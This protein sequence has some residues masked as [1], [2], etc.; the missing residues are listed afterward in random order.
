[1]E[2]SVISSSMLPLSFSSSYQ[3]ISLAFIYASVRVAW[4]EM[5]VKQ[6]VTAIYGLNTFLLP[7][8]KLKTTAIHKIHVVLTPSNI[9]NKTKRNETK[10]KRMLFDLTTLTRKLTVSTW[11]NTFIIWWSVFF[12]VYLEFAYHS[13]KSGN[14]DCFMCWFSIRTKVSASDKCTNRQR[15]FKCVDAIL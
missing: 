1:M 3:A 6:N 9:Q 10:R 5:I 8:M 15:Q 2:L 14:D 7:K 4:C 12:C 11:H 13:D